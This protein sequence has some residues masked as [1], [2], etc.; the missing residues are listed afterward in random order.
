MLFY[1]KYKSI[2]FGFRQELEVNLK[3][4]ARLDLVDLQNLNY[5]FQCVMTVMT[6]MTVKSFSHL[7]SVNESSSL[8]NRGP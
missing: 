4:F 7:L 6:V 3:T 5:R 1:S 8:W 2:I